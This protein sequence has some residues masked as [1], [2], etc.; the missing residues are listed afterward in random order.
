MLTLDL[1]NRRLSDLDKH[2]INARNRGGMDVGGKG[3][4]C[5]LLFVG[6][7]WVKEGST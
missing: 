6:V 2:P 5:G 1:T 7:W 4:E 3:N